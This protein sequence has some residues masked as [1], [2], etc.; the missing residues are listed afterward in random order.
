MYILELLIVWCVVLMNSCCC[1]AS[2]GFK[3]KILVWTQETIGQVLSPAR[4]TFTPSPRKKVKLVLQ[5]CFHPSHIFMCSE[6]TISIRSTGW[7]SRPGVCLEAQTY[8]GG[9]RHSRET[10]HCIDSSTLLLSSE[11]LHNCAHHGAQNTACILLA[12]HSLTITLTWLTHW[13]VQETQSSGPSIVWTDRACSYLDI[14]AHGAENKARY[15]RMCMHVCTEAYENMVSCM[16][17]CVCVCVCVLQSWSMRLF[18]HI[19]TYIHTCT[20]LSYHIE[21]EILTYLYAYIHAH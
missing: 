7:A 11:K 13:R 1:S 21:G 5:A 6:K 2:L 17:V 19:D 4:S 3:L 18:Y 10:L 16:C 14:R 9:G 8:K 20:H 15:V 12:Q